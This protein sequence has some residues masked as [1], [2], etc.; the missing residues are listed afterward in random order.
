MEAG[1]YRPA[2]TVRHERLPELDA[3]GKAQA[4]TGD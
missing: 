2:A 1:F 3:A 4:G